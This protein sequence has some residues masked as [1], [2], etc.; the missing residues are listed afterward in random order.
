M[1]ARSLPGPPCTA[2]AGG[3]GRARQFKLLSSPWLLGC[4]CSGFGSLGFTDAW[5]EGATTVRW[6]TARWLLDG[7]RAALWL[8][9][10]PASSGS[11][12]LAVEA[13][14]MLLSGVAGPVHALLPGLHAGSSGQP[15]KPH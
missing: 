14:E 3:A 13:S 6:L 10:G 15:S 9:L 4:S 5:D 7:A 1:R 12:V 2:A 8:L 11:A